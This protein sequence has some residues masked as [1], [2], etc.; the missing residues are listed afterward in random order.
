MF[1]RDSNFG[2]IT[3]DTSGDT[4]PVPVLSY[5]VYDTH[6]RAAWTPMRLK[7]SDLQNGVSS[8]R[9]KIDALS[10]ERQERWTAGGPYYPVR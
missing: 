10:L 1:N 2:L 8:W 9:E 6:G 4:D 7:A 5:N 3:F